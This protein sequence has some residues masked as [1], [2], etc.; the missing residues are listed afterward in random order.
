MKASWLV[1]GVLLAGCSY[2][3]GSFRSSEPFE[4]T[5]ATTRCLDVAVAARADGARTLVTYAFGSRCK[6]ETVVDL[7]A[8]RAIVR[9]ADRSVPLVAFDPRSEIRA[10]PI[11]GFTSGRETIEYERLTEAALDE[12]RSGPFALAAW[13]PRELCVEIN[14]IERTT[15][16]ERWLCAPIQPEAR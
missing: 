13:Q 6:T 9:D 11:D 16:G 8:V 2:R 12:Q 15:S 7:S 1:G 10:L 5:R 4:G 14:A 3:P